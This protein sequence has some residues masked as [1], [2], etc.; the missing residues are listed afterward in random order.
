QRVVGGHGAGVPSFMTGLRQAWPSPSTPRPIVIVGA[1]AIVRTA[2]LPAYAGL[3]FPVA[4][5]FD[6]R[7]DTARATA[8]MFGVETVFATLDDACA[9]SGAVFDLAVPGDQIL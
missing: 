3:R 7:A 8:A 1:G 4:G 9:V 5:L 6:V 2:H